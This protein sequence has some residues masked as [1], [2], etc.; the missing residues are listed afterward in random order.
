MPPRWYSSKAESGA[1]VVT[2]LENKGGSGP[3]ID[4]T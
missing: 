2:D 1:L 3:T 4:E